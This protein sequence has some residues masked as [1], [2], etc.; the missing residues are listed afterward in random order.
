MLNE[1]KHRII[2]LRGLKDPSADMMRVVEQILEAAVSFS[3]EEFHF[4]FAGGPRSY[5]NAF[6]SSIAWVSNEVM[7]RYAA[8]RATLRGMRTSKSLLDGDLRVEIGLLQEIEDVREEINMVQRVFREQERVVGELHAARDPNCDLLEQAGGA[9]GGTASSFSHPTLDFFTR[10][11][12]D[13]NR[14]RDSVGFPFS[15]SFLC[16]PQTNMRDSDHNPA[17]P[18]STRS[19]Y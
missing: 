1:F 16:W 11:E 4:Q 5:T 9:G 19:Q 3:E 6:A 10:L 8:F 2:A 14:V 15:F 13:A 17:G 18:P 7:K 12:M